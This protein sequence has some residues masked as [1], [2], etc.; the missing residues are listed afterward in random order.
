[1]RS[2][3]AGDRGKTRENRSMR[4]PLRSALLAALALL[5]PGLADAAFITTRDCLPQYKYVKR[6]PPIQYP[7]PGLPPVEI[8]E[9][10]HTSFTPLAP[11]TDVCNAPP[12]PNPGDTVTHSFGSSIFGTIL[13]PAIGI[14]APTPFFAPAGVTVRLTLLNDNGIVGDGNIRIFETEMLMLDITGG[15]LPPGVS[16]QE[17]PSLASLGMTTITDLPGGFFAIDSFFDV[18]TE[19][20]LPPLP[21]IPGTT[22]PTN[23]V[24]VPA[25]VMLNPAPATSWL[26]L[27][28][29][30]ALAAGARS[31]RRGGSG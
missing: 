7:I 14:N 18:F 26:A 20:V 21:P 5:T 24:P 13:A 27:L 11:A 25:R 2:S 31:R 23:P 16:I 28:A 4:Y 29:L 30:A 3:P 15:S 19:L 22:D 1:M 6:G 8:L 17:S 12:G 9:V 10:L